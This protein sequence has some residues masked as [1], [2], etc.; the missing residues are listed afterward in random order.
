M[1]ETVTGKG[2]LF[3]YGW[4]IVGVG[5]VT[6]GITFGIWYSFSVFFPCYYKGFWM[7][8]RCR[9]EYFFHFYHFTGRHRV[10]GRSSSGPDRT[11]GCHTCWDGNIVYLF[12]YD[13]PRPELMGVLHRLWR[14][15]GCGCQPVGVLLSFC[16]YT[17]MVCAQAGPCHWDRYVGNRFRYAVPGAPC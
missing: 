7:E 11:P 14:V 4:V 10:I 8:S 16:L 17:Q 6:L 9:F 5:F 15:C 1:S 2:P 12:G 3:F 13:E